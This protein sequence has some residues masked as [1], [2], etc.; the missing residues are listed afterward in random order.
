MNKRDLMRLLTAA[1][2]TITVEPAFARAT[3]SPKESSEGTYVG[4][5]RDL[6]RDRLPPV[7]GR[8]EAR[9]YR[10]KGGREFPKEKETI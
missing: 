9:P 7:R 4:Q 5:A 6:G 10:V 8:A 2:A 3:D 1:L